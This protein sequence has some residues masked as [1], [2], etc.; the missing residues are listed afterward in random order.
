MINSYLSQVTAQLSKAS[1]QYNNGVI[2]FLLH[3]EDGS[4]L[5]ATRVVGDPVHHHNVSPSGI[6]PKFPHL[7]TGLG[8]RH[9][10]A[11]PAK[12]VMPF[13][14]LQMLSPQSWRKSRSSKS[15]CSLDLI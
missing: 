14:I 12:S 15:E 6:A 4:D 11:V 1:G 5:Q 10:F 2:S 9:R 3:G 7:P 13:T 8:S